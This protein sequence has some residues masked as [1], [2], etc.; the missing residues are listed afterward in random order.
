MGVTLFNI[1]W[2]D[3]NHCFDFP[4]GM[5]WLFLDLRHFKAKNLLFKLIASELHAQ[6]N[7]KSKKTQY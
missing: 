6:N 4:I 2:L 3:W 7:P 1:K 5:Y